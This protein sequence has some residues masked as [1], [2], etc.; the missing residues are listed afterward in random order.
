MGRAE[1]R[2]LISDLKICEYN[3]DE[4]RDFIERYNFCNNLRRTGRGVPCIALVL[5]AGVGA[6][7]LGSYVPSLMGLPSNSLPISDSNIG[8]ICMGFAM[9]STFFYFASSTAERLHISNVAYNLR[10][11]KRYG[12]DLPGYEGEDLDSL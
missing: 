11:K 10:H 9:G 7:V 5:S 6:Y 12:R 2:S 3:S 1:L 4:R 8:S